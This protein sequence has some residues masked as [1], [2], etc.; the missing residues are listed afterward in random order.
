M[1]KTS[2]SPDF[3]FTMTESYEI[4]YAQGEMNDRTYHT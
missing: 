3:H 4:D 1:N 2:D